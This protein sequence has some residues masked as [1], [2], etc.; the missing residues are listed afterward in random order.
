M[1]LIFSVWLRW[2][3]SFGRGTW[4]HLVLPAITLGTYE[5][6]LTYGC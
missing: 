3:P 5:L 2:L 6:A 4:W 1:I